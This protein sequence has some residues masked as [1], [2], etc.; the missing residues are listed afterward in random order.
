V[1][2]HSQPTAVVG[3]LGGVPIPL[4]LPFA[5]LAVPA[6]ALAIGGGAVLSL[7]GISPASLP[8]LLLARGDVLVFVGAVV[9]AVAAIRAV[10][11]VGGQ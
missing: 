3:V 7:L 5:L 1:F 6:V 4:L 9:V 8:P 11:R 10:E 2:P